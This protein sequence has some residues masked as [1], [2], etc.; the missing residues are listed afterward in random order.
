MASFT[1]TRFPTNI[2]QGSSGGPGF[3]TDVMMV[4][5]GF[6]ERKIKWSEQRSIFNVAYGIRSVDDYEALLNFFVSMRGKAYGFRYKDWADYKSC[7]ITVEPAFDDQIIGS[8]NGATTSFQLI[9][10]YTAGFTYQRNITKPVIGSILVGIGG[11]ASSTNF[12]ADTSAGTITFD[13]ITKTVINAVSAG[14]NTTIS[15][16]SHGLVDGDSVYLSSF[17]GDWIALNSTRFIV[18]VLDSATFNIV[19]NSSLF[20][21]YSANGGQLKTLPQ[22]GESVTA[23]YEFDLPCR[24]DQDAISTVINNYLSFS[25]DVM[26]VEIKV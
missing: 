14:S 12:V 22:T 20:T 4:T 24:F 1:E 13:N 2:S 6:E 7:S 5:S 9:K 23:G 10:N 11:I 3:K 8:G 16:T 18:D 25:T 17:T 21:A 19:F 26:V 15:A